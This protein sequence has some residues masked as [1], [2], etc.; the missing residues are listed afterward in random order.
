MVIG[1]LKDDWILA[2]MFVSVLVLD[3]TSVIITN[4]DLNHRFE[5]NQAKSN[6]LDLINN[7]DCVIV[8]NT[9]NI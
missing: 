4:E 3:F 2:V 6:F 7:D 8:Y 1:K 9:D 5:F